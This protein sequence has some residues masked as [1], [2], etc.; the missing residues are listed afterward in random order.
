LTKGLI[1]AIFKTD[2]GQMGILGSAQ[3]LLQTTLPQRSTQH[4]RRL[5][6]DRLN[7]AIRSPYLFKDL[8]ERLLIYLSGGKVTFPD[9]LDLFQATTFQRQVWESTRLIPYG[10]TRSYTWVAR[11]SG[12]PRAARATGQALAKNPLPIIVPCHRVVTNGSKL[13]GFTGGLDMKRHLL[14]LE[15]STFFDSNPPETSSM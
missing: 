2:T 14:Y 8:I 4:V 7:Y 1:Y 13:G 5:L 10:E 3:G 15:G 6:G 11:Q 9:R 12:K